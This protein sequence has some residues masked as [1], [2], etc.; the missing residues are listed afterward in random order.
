MG[1][2]FFTWTVILLFHISF[3]ACN[4]I[5]KRNTALNFG[6]RC[7][8][9]YF[10][11]ESLQASI[12]DYK[13][14]LNKRFSSRKIEASFWM[15]IHLDSL[16]AEIG[17]DQ[18]VLWPLLRPEQSFL[19]YSKFP[20]HLFKEILRPELDHEP[21]H[22]VVLGKTDHNL[23]RVVH[24]YKL[25]K[26]PGARLIHCIKEQDLSEISPNKKAIGF[27]CPTE[28]FTFRE[29]HWVISKSSKHHTSKS[30]PRRGEFPIDFNDENSI[31]GINRRLK[32]IPITGK[33]KS[34]K[35]AHTILIL[36]KRD[37]IIGMLQRRDKTYLRCKLTTSE[38]IIPKFIGSAIKQKPP[39]V[40]GVKGKDIFQCGPISVDT[41]SVF[42]SARMAPKSFIS[43]MENFRIVY[44]KPVDGIPFGSLDEL[45]LWP[46]HEISKG[47]IPGDPEYKC[48]KSRTI[49]LVLDYY[50][51]I[52]SMVH[53]SKRE[54]GIFLP[55]VRTRQTYETS[56]ST[57]KKRIVA[58]LYQNL[59]EDMSD[60]KKS[61]FDH[62]SSQGV[63]K[64]VSSG[65]EK[66]R[67]LTIMAL[68]ATGK[69]R[70]TT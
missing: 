59:S 5:R 34:Y 24:L 43:K 32:Q 22:F 19:E 42:E 6:Y 49:F 37:M 63:S 25:D 7:D 16:E 39:L 13:A 48:L 70:L 44:P 50:S 60:G 68:P 14:Y 1:Y 27:R 54:R 56:P 69:G 41:E 31:F 33:G 51:D 15:K 17:R 57:G 40:G 38:F 12:N 29:L 66:E 61:K 20:C 8:K 3:S 62:D 46:H 4:G 58:D 52:V 65:V 55:C 2:Y 11:P 35:K 10:P 45:F 47:R 36:D 64:D 18:N 67:R 28:A 53:L 30:R 21:V 26:R 23:L 9:T